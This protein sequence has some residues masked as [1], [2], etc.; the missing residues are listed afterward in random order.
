M[1]Q[2]LALGD[3]L[4]IVRRRVPHIIAPFLAILVAAVFV[5]LLLPPIYRSTATV[6]VESQQIP[7]DLV[8]TTVQGSADERIGY[9]AQIVMTDAR[10]EETIHRF[11]LYPE[12]L[13]KNPMPAVVD[14]LRRNIEVQAI[15]DP[16]GSR[17]TI[18]FTVSFDHPDPQMARDVAATLVELFLAENART[19]NARATE[20]AAFLKQE[21]QRLGEEVRSLDKQVAEFKRQHSDALPEHLNLRVNMLQSAEFDLRAVQR[22]IAATEQERRF[23]ETQLGVL[24]ARPPADRG[25]GSLELTP[26]QRLRSLRA[27]LEAASRLY[28]Q[29]HPDVVRLKRLVGEAEVDVQRQAKNPADADRLVP[30]DPERA[31]IEGKIA[32][33]ETRLGSLRDQE[34]ELSARVKTLQAQILKTHEVEQGLREIN[35]LYQAASKDYDGVREKLQQAELAENLE[36]QHMAERFVLLEPASVPVRPARPN[37]MKLLILGFFLALGGGAG[38]AVAAEALDSR[39][40]DP[41]ML[42]RL[43]GV[44]PLAVL[45]YVE[46]RHERRNRVLAASAA[47]LGFAGLLGLAV[48]AGLQF[49]APIAEA[50]KRVYY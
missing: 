17:A 6:A 4:R 11:G 16:Y 45:P 13:A 23:L 15:R 39:V 25:E 38:V 3:Y 42:A 34:Q 40:R 50:L 28:T 44:R 2:Q 31:Q 10:L 37:R 47:W 48:V 14:K 27:E 9:I 5:V 33:A 32:S 7:T 29:A 12:T 43:I 21:T 30:R 26:E 46:L 1:D 36:S 35:L 41:T 49:T 24:V 20:T 22:D 19:R 8:R 18:A